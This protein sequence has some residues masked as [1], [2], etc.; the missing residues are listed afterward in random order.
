MGKAA[1][2]K[3]F[4]VYVVIDVNGLSSIAPSPR[5]WM[6]SWGILARLK[7]VMNLWRRR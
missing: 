3:L 2:A 4:V 7:W 1:F 5:F 6:N